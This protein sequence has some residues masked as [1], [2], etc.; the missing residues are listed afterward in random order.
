[1]P[2]ICVFYGIRI[3]MYFDDHMPPHFHAT[4]AG[5]ESSI[6]IETLETL[7]GRL[8]SRARSLV[9]EWADRHRVELA[10]NWEKAREHR[11][12]DAIAPLG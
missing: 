12:L 3:Y 10:A 5:W 4:Y 8:P 6:A 9:L 1:M 2:R 7:K 11:P